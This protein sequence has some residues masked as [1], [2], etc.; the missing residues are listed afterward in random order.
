MN[1]ALKEWSS[2][3]AA[4]DRGMQT[5]LLR[6][7]GIVESKRGFELRHREFLLFPTFEHQHARWLKPELGDLV[8]GAAESMG[9]VVISHVACVADIIDAP[10]SLDRL[11]AIYDRHVWNRDFIQ[12]RYEYRPDLPLYMIVIRVRRLDAPC[13]IP[14]RASYAG[15]KSWVHL[16]EEI[17][18]EGGAWVL[19]DAEFERRRN[20]L[21]VRTRGDLGGGFEHR[22]Q[23]AE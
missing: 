17:P 18:V 14:S 19:P 10:R 11:E 13:A 1:V 16:T 4:L 12:S 2:V 21:V 20:D 15:C 23:P 6:K 8:A 22:E 5:F 3:I 9:N 7:G